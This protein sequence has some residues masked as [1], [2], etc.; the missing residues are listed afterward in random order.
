M[1]KD[2]LPPGATFCLNAA[3]SERAVSTAEPIA[4]PLPVAAVVLPRASRESVLARTLESRPAIS[5]RPPALSATGPYASVARVIP[6]VASI[7]TAAMLT[8]YAGSTWSGLSSAHARIAATRITV[9]GPQEIIPTPIPWMTTVA[10]P[11]RPAFLME[12]VGEKS[13][14]VKY[15]VTFPISIPEKRPMRMHPYSLQPILLSPNIS[16]ITPAAPATKRKP[17]VYI[18]FSRAHMSVPR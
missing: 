14:E 3:M 2:I 13:K 11:V 12:I 5:T 15:S 8:P 7:P 10:G 17:A 1:S 4:N 9:G 18:P 6:R 16:P